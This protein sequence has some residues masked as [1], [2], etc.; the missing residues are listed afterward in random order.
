MSRCSLLGDLPLGPG[1][2]PELSDLLEGEAH[3][4]A[5]V[6]ENEPV[7]ASLVGLA[8]RRRL[9]S[10]P[11]GEAHKLPVELGQ[12]PSVCRVEH[13]LADPRFHSAL[14]AHELGGRCLAGPAADTATPAARLP[15]GIPAL[16]IGFFATSRPGS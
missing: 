14:L 3:A 1:R 15:K 12:A 13:D 11:V 10:C 9:V 8:G 2:R 5:R 16:C 6:E 7:A 4:S